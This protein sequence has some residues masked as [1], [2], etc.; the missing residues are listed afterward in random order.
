MNFL[1]F[2]CKPRNLGTFTQRVTKFREI[3]IHWNLE[4]VLREISPILSLPARCH[5]KR[6][7]LTKQVGGETGPARSLMA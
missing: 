4:T 7:R 5:S 3:I 6:R 2:S 1:R